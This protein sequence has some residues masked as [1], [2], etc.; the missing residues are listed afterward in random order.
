MGEAHPF[1]QHVIALGR[2]KQTIGKLVT[3]DDQANRFL[4]LLF[5]IDNF[6]PFAADI[7]RMHQSR[8]G[9]CQESNRDR[10]AQNGNN[11]HCQ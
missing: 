3:L 2:R 5:E 8:T 6:F 4:G 1:E 9:I 7:G 10:P 11:G